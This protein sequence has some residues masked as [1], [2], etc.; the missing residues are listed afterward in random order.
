V[1]ESLLGP[2]Q[3]YSGD[4]AKFEVYKGQV[5]SQDLERLK[6]YEKDFR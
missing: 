1:I 4:T 3:K 5:K 2:A 6:A